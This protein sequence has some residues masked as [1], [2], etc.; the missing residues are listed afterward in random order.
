MTEE[1]HEMAQTR[2]PSPPFGQT[3]GE[4]Q[5]A[6]HQV[7]VDVLDRAGVT[8]DRWVAMNTLGTRGPAIARDELVQNLA[9]GL[10]SD[11]SGASNLL[12]QLASGGLVRV[13]ADAAGQDGPLV[14]LTDTGRALHRTLRER[15]G[16]T[17]AALLDGL[18]PT[19]VQTTI[20]VLRAVTQR[21]ARYTSPRE[22]GESRSGAA[23]GA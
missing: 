20:T 8:F 10:Q 3:V 16:H 4:A 9:Y 1:V 23:A 22:A 13:T 12:D 7:I 11:A 15:V 6:L 14:E 17:S 18:D 19:Q 21:A 5:T 2:P